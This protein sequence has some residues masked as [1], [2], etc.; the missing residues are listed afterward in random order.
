MEKSMIKISKLIAVFFVTLFLPLFL[1]ANA[2]DK[3]EFNASEPVLITSAGQSAD[4]LMIKLL[5]EKASLNILFDKSAPVQKVDSVSSVIIVSG[6]SSK[7]LG[8]AR[9]DKE[10][11]YKRVQE[12]LE[13]AKKEEKP[14]IGAHVGGKSRRG[15]LSD[16]FNQLVAEN[17]D[18]LIVVKD[19]DHDSYFSELATKR[20]IKVTLP[21]KITDI[22]NILVEIFGK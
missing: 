6:G 15:K 20:N 17:A 16:Y 7:G 14:I 10:D 8:A 22:Q 3:V 2:D 9:I 5:A 4:V 19:G 18:Y 11:E 13:K 1:M 21:E 12:I